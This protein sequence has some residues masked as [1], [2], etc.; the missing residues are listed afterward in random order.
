M[1]VDC[2]FMLNKGDIVYDFDSTILGKCCHKSI[3]GG[4]KMVCLENGPYIIWIEGKC[5]VK[6]Q[7][8]KPSRF[9]FSDGE[10][11]VFYKDL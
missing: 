6:K 3:N 11:T 4:K 7:V 5:Y 9:V 2:Y 10:K 8:G 1:S